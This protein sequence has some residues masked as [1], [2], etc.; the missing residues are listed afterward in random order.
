ML[1]TV[2]KDRLS[3]KKT[4]ITTDDTSCRSAATGTRFATF[5]FNIKHSETF[6]I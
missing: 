6:E 3:I 4:S 5:K 1:Q 2:G